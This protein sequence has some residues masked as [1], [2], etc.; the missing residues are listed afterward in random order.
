[1]ANQKLAILGVTDLEYDGGGERNAVQFA[2]VASRLGYDVTIY[3]GGCYFERSKVVNLVNA[4]YIRNA[5]SFDFFARKSI[6]RLTRGI[7]IG[8]VGLF[9]FGRIW[10]IVSSH[11]VYYFQNPNFMF[12]RFIES[13]RKQGKSPLIIL[14][15][16][17]TY[18]EILSSPGLRIL[19]WAESAIS[20]IIF[21]E[22]PR[23]IEVQAQNA[24]QYEFYK[25]K[26]FRN[27]K[28]VPQCQVDFRSYRVS[29]D[30]KFN[31]V[32]L[33]KLTGNKGV[34]LLV[35][36]LESANPDVT[37]HIIGFGNIDRLRKRVRNDNVIFYG[38]VDEKKKE[39]ILS[40]CDLMINC[41]RYESLSISSVEGL[42]SGLPIVGPD[43]SGMKYIKELMGENVV[44]IKR[45]VGEY[46][47]AIE[48]FHRMKADDPVSYYTNRVHIREKAYEKFDVSV[49]EKLLEDL[50]HSVPRGTVSESDAQQ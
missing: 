31:V 36:I 40:R 33:N 5:F 39:D 9:G 11:D 17:G 27:V 46:L 6:I 2:N 21:K 26:D 50:L 44:I 47:K 16:H 22:V 4:K 18:F 41:S 32:F 3:G 43:I 42:A 34:D 37:Y 1:L 45:D 19:S 48:M 30:G 15:N 24:F 10:N 28:I 35:K 13:S 8:L 7:S 29:E 12:K 23:D 20:R 25:G 38:Q 14:A 49:I